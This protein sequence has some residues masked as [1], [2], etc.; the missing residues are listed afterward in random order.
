MG[1]N[2]LIKRYKELDCSKTYLV[3]GGAGFIAFHLSKRL[4]EL[5]CKIIGF[6]NLNNYT[7]EKLKINRLEIL[8][9]YDNYT[10]VK[11]DLADRDAVT[12]LFDS[13]SPDIV[14]HLGAQAGIRYSIENPY[15]YIQSNIV[16]FFN[17]LEE[18]RHHPIE[19]LVYASS[20]SVYGVNKKIPFSAGDQVDYPISLYAATKKSDELMAYAYSHLYGIPTTGLRFF[21]VYGPLG[22][23]DMA[24]FL[25][26]RQILAGNSIKVYNYG[27]MYRDFTF[28]DDVVDAVKRILCNPPAIDENGTTYKIYNIGNNKPEKLLYFIE[29]LERC[30]G[31]KAQ[32]EFL[33]MQPG[34][35]YKTYADINSLVEDF[36]FKPSTPIEIGLDKF[37]KWYTAYYQS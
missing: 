18:C 4:L 9:Q 10:F 32:I 25:F 1:E 8:K 29:I 26:T 7:D 35:V 11:G 17:V 15:I 5:G 27:D 12:K 31:E 13:C 24:Y 23:S 34:D 36:D 37:V 14:V 28:V 30:L 16:G 3:T 20:S 19:H 33:P 6:D 22:R 2:Y 21:T